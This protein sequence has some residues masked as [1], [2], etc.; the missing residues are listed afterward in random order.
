MAEELCTR[1]TPFTSADKAEYIKRS[2]V[3]QPEGGSQCTSYKW[4]LILK[5]KLIDLHMFFPHKTNNNND[6]IIQKTC[7]THISRN[8]GASPLLFHDKCPG[9]FYVHY[10]THGTYSFTSHPKDEAIMVKCLAQG[11]KR[12]DHHEIGQALKRFTATIV[13]PEVCY[14]HA[15]C[16]PANQSTVLYSKWAHAQPAWYRVWL[17]CLYR[18]WLPCLYRVRLPCLYRVWLPC[19]Y[20]V[21]LPCLYRV[22][23]PCLYRVWLPCLYRVWLPCLYRVWLPCL[24]RVWLPCL[25]RVWLPCLYRVWLPC[26]YRVRL[27]CLY[28]V[29]LPCLYRVWLPCL[30][31]V[32]LPCL[33]RVGCHACTEFG[34]PALGYHGIMPVP[35]AC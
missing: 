9:F 29:W 10:T 22:W 7:S 17:P 31:R 24:Y 30:Y 20:R 32:W 13:I 19:L 21:W 16:Q 6:I 12:R 15:V 14:L 25:Y 8:T 26:L 33:Y 34:Y 28:R 27:P 5:R 23:L 2:Y 3:Y 4:P 11:H 18:V 1:V 35:L